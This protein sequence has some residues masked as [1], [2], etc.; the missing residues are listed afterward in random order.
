MPKAH[1]WEVQTTDYA[2]LVPE[3]KHT[4]PLETEQGGLGSQA[5]NLGK[6]GLRTLEARIAPG[7]GKPET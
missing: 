1:G 3:D 2:K 7:A 6:Q 4:G 5:H